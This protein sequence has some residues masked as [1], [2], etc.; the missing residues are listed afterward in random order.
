MF[1]FVVVV[2]CQRARL[3]KKMIQER[4]PEEGGGGGCL[5]ELEL[6]VAEAGG[7]VY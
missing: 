6:T 2:A 4:Q 3:N 7:L 5:F 1:C